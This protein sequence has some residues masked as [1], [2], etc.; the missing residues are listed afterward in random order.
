MTNTQP[1]APAMQIVTPVPANSTQP[2]AMQIVAAMP[3][4]GGVSLSGQPISVYAGPKSI[5]KAIKEYMKR[6][7]LKAYQNR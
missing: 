3:A 1:E 7:G 2:E 4:Y 5:D 6:F